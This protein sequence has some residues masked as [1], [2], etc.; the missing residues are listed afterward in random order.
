MSLTAH[1]IALK[2]S[3]STPPPLL[4][5]EIRR[6]VQPSLGAE[7]LQADDWGSWREA[8]DLMSADQKGLGHRR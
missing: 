1:L 8:L 3:P 7:A 6:L 4:V 2:L 5:Y